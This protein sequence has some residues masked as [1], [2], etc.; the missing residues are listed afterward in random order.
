MPDRRRPFYRRGARRVVG[1]RLIIVCE[2]RSTEP[3]YFNAI[4]QS[5]RLP[6]AQVYV[7]HPDA[8]D[9]LSIVHAAIEYR[10]ERLQERAWVEGDSAWAVFDGDEHRG[11]NPHNWNDAIQTAD[12]KHINLAVSNPCFELWYL[13]H[14]QDQFAQLSR[15]EAIQRIRNHLGEYEKA[16]VYWPDPLGPFTAEALE[17]AKGLARRLAAEGAERHV[18]PST[19]LFQLVESLLNLERETHETG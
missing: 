16:R 2:G 14:Y 15:D 6:T 1:R 3:G 13:L 18:N 11:A 12:S 9:P 17:R 5:M 10:R 7:V 19:D 4:R 8:T